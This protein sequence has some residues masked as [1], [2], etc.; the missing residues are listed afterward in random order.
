VH[1]CAVH[2]TETKRNERRPTISKEFLFSSM[3]SFLLILTGTYVENTF[4]RCCIREP[5]RIMT[6]ASDALVTSVVHMF[7]LHSESAAH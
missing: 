4:E 6:T 2:G 7:L 1:A 3:R 5:K